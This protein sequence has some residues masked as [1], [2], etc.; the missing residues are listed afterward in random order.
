MTRF[1]ETV[2]PLLLAPLAS[3]A[4]LTCWELP[5]Q[6]LDAIFA[7]IVAAPFCYA[8]EVLLVV[9]ILLLWPPSRSPSLFVAAIWGAAVAWC[10]AAVTA[11]GLHEMAR[12]IVVAGF[13]TSGVAS[14]VAYALLARRRS[15]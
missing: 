3:A 4:V 11:P 5:R 8:A 15:N 6:G 10:A 13:G 12:P 1:R 14:G 7:G 9:P 2:R